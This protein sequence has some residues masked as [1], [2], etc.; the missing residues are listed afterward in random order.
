M[1]R[2]LRRK[3]V[4]D[5]ADPSE[6]KMDLRN[7]VAPIL[8]IYE[9]FSADVTEAYDGLEHNPAELRF[10]TMAATSV[11]IQAFGDLPQ[12]K[13]QALVG[14]FY[15]QSAAN[16]LLFMPQADFSLVHSAATQRFATYADS[17]VEVINAGTEQ[18]Q[19]DAN[20]SL[21][22]LLDENLRVDRGAFDRSIQG[23]TLGSSLVRYAA[24]VRDAAIQ[25]GGKF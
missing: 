22:T 14:V 10:F 23:L 7:A 2:F 15:E 8:T 24:Q 20:L 5:E 6:L 21:M 4:A 19:Q 16:M 9:E 11:F 1:F 25:T 13:M 18:A 12:E 17:I 3:K